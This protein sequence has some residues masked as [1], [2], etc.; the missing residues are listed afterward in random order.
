MPPYEPI[1]SARRRELG[2]ELR[3]VRLATGMSATLLADRLG[4]SASKLSRIESGK[5]SC[6]EVEAAMLLGYCR[7]EPK[8][9]SRILA[10]CTE[11]DDGSWLQSHGSRL[12]DQ[13]RTLVLHETT[14]SAMHV[15]EISR[16]D[17]LLQTEDYA[18]EMMRG[19]GL[20]PEPGIEPRV[21]ARMA[22]QSLLRRISPPDIVFYMHEA[23]LRLQV[24]GPQV[25]HEQ[26]LH[27]LLLSS[28]SRCA[29]R[30]IPEGIGPHAGLS[31]P[32]RLMQYKDHP[33]VIYIETQNRSLILE[34]HADIATYWLILGKL[35][36]AALSAEE[37]RSVLADYASRYDRAEASHDHGDD[38]A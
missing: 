9:I 21:R 34:S 16:V 14:A 11:H 19:A 20:V 22:R 23:A 12:P 29:I 7:A 36:E 27:L 37:S 10:L 25:M 13:L 18:R 5:T 33:S 17:G 3:R 4:W 6:D 35:A 24:G 32:F 1:A 8:E 30:V 15:L 2:D 31:G 38:L 26:L 28:Q